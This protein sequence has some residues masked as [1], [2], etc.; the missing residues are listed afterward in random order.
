M[1]RAKKECIL[2]EAAKAFARYGFKKASVDA[3]ARRAGVAKGTV[4]LAANSKE[5]LFY[6]VLHREVRAW[7]A[8]IAKVIDPREPADQLLIAASQIGL[9]YID[10]RPLLK[11]L[12]FGEAHLIL[13][14]WGDRLDALIA[15]GGENATQILRL[16]IQQ[17][18][19]RETIDVEM[20]AQLLLDLQ[21]A[22]FVLHDRGPDREARL[23]RRRA[24]A[25]DLIFHGLKKT[26]VPALSA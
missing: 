7:I 12:L 25:L 26:P 20:V 13:P 23:L 19:F 22:F 15:L 8:E 24:A 10:S 18:I 21:L 3:I 5:D 9:E 17:G 14:E 11:H 2:V 1:E 6:Q 16:G 4:Y